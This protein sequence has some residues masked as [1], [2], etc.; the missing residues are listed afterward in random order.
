MQKVHYFYGT[1]SLG[2]ED[3]LHCRATG[4]YH[5]AERAYTYP[6]EYAPTDPPEPASFEIGLIEIQDREGNWHPL[7][8]AILSAEQLSAIEEKAVMENEA[9]MPRR[10]WA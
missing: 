8:M 2:S 7:S 10:R 3:D 4:V 5:R 6:G 1:L 9:E